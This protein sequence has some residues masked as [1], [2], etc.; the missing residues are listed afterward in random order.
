MIKIDD[1][2]KNLNKEFWEVPG[3]EIK[4]RIER[5]VVTFGEDDVKNNTPGISRLLRKDFP[6]LKRMKYWKNFS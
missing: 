4:N 6:T 3:K 2:L 1:I 5:I